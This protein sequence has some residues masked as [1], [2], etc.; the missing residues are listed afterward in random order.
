MSDGDDGDMQGEQKDC[1]RGLEARSGEDRGGVVAEIRGEE[2]NGRGVDGDG[3]GGAG[4]ALLRKS[5][6]LFHSLPFDCI[7]WVIWLGRAEG[8]V[9]KSHLP[10]YSI[11]SC[12]SQAPAYFS[13][14]SHVIDLA[15]TRLIPP[16]PHSSVN[17]SISFIID[18]SIEV[19]SR[20]YFTA[21]QPFRLTLHRIQM[22]IWSYSIHLT[23]YM[24]CCFRLD[25]A[26]LGPHHDLHEEC[27]YYKALMK[28]IQAMTPSGDPLRLQKGCYEAHSDDAC[29]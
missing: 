7:I 28:E 1:G 21:T 17:I 10:M 15:S 4:W 26:R 13:P 16:Q 18:F 24:A 14:S 29:L 11:R 22:I 19:Y 8:Y 3:L 23:K 6:L 27:P 12:S 20:L 2:R 9:H 5:K 25:F